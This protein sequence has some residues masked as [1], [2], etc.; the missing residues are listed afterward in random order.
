MNIQIKNLFNI[1]V[2]S[3]FLTTIIA[4]NSVKKT[5][6]TSQEQID[7]TEK[8]ES[9]VKETEKIDKETIVSTTGKITKDNLTID[10]EPKFDTFGNLIP[11]S[12]QKKDY[13]GNETNVNI[14]GNGKVTYNTV[15]ELK[16]IKETTKS[17]TNKELNRLENTIKSLEQKIIKL[18]KNK[19]VKPDYFKYI[20]WV[21]IG[22]LL[23]AGAIIGVYFYIRNKLTII[24]TFIP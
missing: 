16:D 19:A 8:V 2:V 14:K 21:G 17:V 6:T 20:I 22:F 4:C 13:Q 5:K 24:K 15:T 12:F 18:E 1:I 7:K 11:F 10:Y 9:V 23:L 3:I